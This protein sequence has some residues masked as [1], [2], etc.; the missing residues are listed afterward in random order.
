MI[1]P[2]QDRTLNARASTPMLRLLLCAAA[3]FTMAN[4]MRPTACAAQRLRLPEIERRYDAV[5]LVADARSGRLLGGAR[6]GE[7]RDERFYPGSLFKLAIAVAALRSGSFDRSYTYSCAG[8]DTIA[9]SVQWCWN[10]HGHATIGFRQAIALSCNLYFRHVAR[11]LTTNQIAQAA[12]SIGMMPG[13]ADAA[14]TLATINDSTLLGNAFA[15]SPEGMLRVALAFA[16]RGRLSAGGLDLSG[17]AYRP[18]Y[19]GLRECARS[20]TGKDA[21]SPRFSVGGKTGTAEV[22]GAPHHT[23]GWFIGFAPFDRPKYAVVVMYRGARGA[24]AATIAR[25]AL[26]KLL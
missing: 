23:I 4:T 14:G 1:P 11:M 26:E 15:V 25:K 17:A 5:V 13:D 19:D 7:A 21:W 6:V 8:K 12:R 20:G 2:S 16:T 3:V 22:P 10:R 24:E 18:L 9:G